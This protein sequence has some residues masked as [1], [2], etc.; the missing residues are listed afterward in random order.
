MLAA[1]Y[2]HK[3]ETISISHGSTTMGK[4]FDTSPPEYLNSP[5]AAAVRS[6]PIYR[7]SCQIKSEIIAS[8]ILLGYEVKHLIHTHI[9]T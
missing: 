4:R 8:E 7:S 9:H 3:K 1:F 6:D 5:L 2:F